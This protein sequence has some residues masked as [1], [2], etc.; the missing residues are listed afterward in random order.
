M[1]VLIRPYVM[2]D[3]QAVVSLYERASMLDPSIPPIS[4]KGWHR[5]VHQDVNKAGAG[6]F[7]AV[8]DENMVGIAS[9]SLR[10]REN[11]TVRHFRIV[12]DPKHWREGIGTRLLDAL[13]TLDR[14]RADT[15]LQ[16]L[17]PRQ[18][19]A[20]GAFLKR[21]G[22]VNVETE[23]EMVCEDARISSFPPDPDIRIER[24][25]DVASYAEVVT[26]LHN[27]AYAHDVSFV[28]FTPTAMAELLEAAELWILWI[29][30][31]VVGYCHVEAGASAC[32]IESIVVDPHRQNQQLGT[33]LL[34]V[35]VDDI[36]RKRG[37]VA[38]LSVSDRNPAARRVYEKLGFNVVDASMRFRAPH[39][40]VAARIQT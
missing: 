23:F 28:H 34:A 22:F 33:R 16:S 9:S 31:T 35:V 20:G 13:V 26:S 2:V 37:H 25:Q 21:L 29:G 40:V 12:V 7:V 10:C 36:V 1:A 19:D 38:R 3:A 6:F 39:H 4:L 14:T 32:W 18:W 24:V 5:F 15:I 11:E 27:T 8:D 17:C 30:Q